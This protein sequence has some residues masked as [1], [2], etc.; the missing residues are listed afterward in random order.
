[1]PR[2]GAALV[3][4]GGYGRRELSPGSDLDVVLLRPTGICGLATPPTLADRIWYPV[5]DSGVRLDHS[6][7][8][9]AEARRVAADDLRALLGL[10]DVRHVA[11]D[12]GPHRGAARRDPRRLARRLAT[13]RLPELLEPRPGARRARP[14]SWPSPLEPD[15]KESRGGLRDLDGAARRRR[16]W[17]TDPPHA[18]L[19]DAHD[20]L[21]DVRDALH[22]VTGRATDRLVAAGAGRRSRTHLGLLDADQLLRQ[23]GCVGPDR[24]LRARRHLA[25]RRARGADQARPQPVRHRTAAASRRVRPRAPLADGVVEQD[26]EVVLA[27]DAR[28]PDDPVARPARRGRR[29]AGRAAARRR[30]RST[31]SPPRRPP[32]A[33]AVAAAARDALVS[34]LGAGRRGDPGVGGA[35]P[36][37]ASSLRLIPDWERVR[38]R[39]QR[40]PVHRF[41]VDRHLVETAV[42]AAALHPP[43]RPARPAAR[44]RA[45]ARH[46]QGLARRPHRG[47]RGR[48]RRRRA[49]PRLRRRA[50]P[51]RW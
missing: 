10:L 45:A 21:L 14:A 38:S 6:V 23:V 47:R 15:L 44:R 30:T 43:G 33:R 34:L 5:W 13:K 11:G 22:T 9:P 39:P 48:G 27:R 26:G 19:D 4:V 31:G 49:A 16:V 28:P 32:L 20:A 12:V 1:M 2:S 18:G 42:Q 8:T 3:A 51:R 40:N 37:R 25:P 29:R 35:R 36:G 50:T 7:R 17:V 41:T 24:R 46:R